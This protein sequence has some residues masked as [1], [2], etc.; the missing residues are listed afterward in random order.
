MNSVL[1]DTNVVSILFKPEHDRFGVCLDAVSGSQPVISFMT[2]AELMLWPVA[3]NW[4]PFRHQSL[5]SHIR[6]YTT[7]Y[8]DAATCALWSR[9][10]DQCRR[11]GRPIQTADAWI[12]AAAL[13]WKLPLMTVDV[14]DFVAVDGLEIVPIG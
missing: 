1:L 11:A 12:A 14:G 8:P 13:Q 10:T 7:L 9:V 5:L 4:G 2:V 6:I 3:N